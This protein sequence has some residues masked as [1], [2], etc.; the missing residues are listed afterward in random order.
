MEMDMSTIHGH[1]IRDTLRKNILGRYREKKYSYNRRN[2]YGLDP[3]L[4]E[5]HFTNWSSF[6]TQV[7]S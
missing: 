3:Q 2:D 5:E 1:G 7:K 4:W 6:F